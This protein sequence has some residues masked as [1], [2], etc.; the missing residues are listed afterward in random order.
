MGFIRQRL[1]LD[2]GEVSAL[3]LT[4]TTE[5]SSFQHLNDKQ[6]NRNEQCSMVLSCFFSYNI[7]R[8]HFFC[9]TSEYSVWKTSTPWFN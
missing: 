4:R 8:L 1:Y 7:L 3:F 6:G 9:Y 5:L 2:R